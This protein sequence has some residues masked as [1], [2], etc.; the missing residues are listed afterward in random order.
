MRELLVLMAVLSSLPVAAQA[1]I[2]PT[3]PPRATATSE[4]WYVGREPI[5]FAGDVYYPAG[6]TRFFDGN[7]M[8]RTGDYNGV[9]L[10]ADTTLEPFSVV[11]V[12]VA[13][14]QMQPYERARRGDLAGTT[15]SRTPSF[16]VQVTSTTR[17]IP[18]APSAPTGPSVMAEAIGTFTLEPSATP[19]PAIETLAAPSLS[20]A[21]A[22][23]G[24]SGTV[25]PG[26]TSSVSSLLR[27]QGNDGVWIRF[28]GEKWVSAG[29]AVAFRP[30]DFI[31]VGEYAGFPV[32][33]RA[34][35]GEDEDEVYL[36]TRAG[37]V[38]PYRLKD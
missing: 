31:R 19:A 26:Q 4:S 37:I 27:P 6:A 13:S 1:Q 22:A 2:R 11:Y 30:E 5:Q 14:G 15:A 24:V 38:A 25:S 29:R 28:Q 35:G 23:V 9:A 20:A 33:A 32:F 21:T 12:P 36:P 34:G 7:T 8:I 3:D 17:Q 18:M 10:Y 16:P